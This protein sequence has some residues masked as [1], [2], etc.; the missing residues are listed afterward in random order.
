MSDPKRNRPGR[1]G[2]SKVTGQA[3]QPESTSPA[4]V[5]EA[6]TLGCALMST[7][8]RAG[9]IDLLDLD[10]FD[11]EAHRTLFGVL[12]KMHAAGEHVDPITVNDRLH[13]CGLLDEVGGGAAV[14]ELADPLVS[15]SPAA[16][17]NYAEIVVREGRRRRGIRVLQRGID[18]LEAGDDPAVVAADM[19]V[20]V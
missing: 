12:V 5:A 9:I 16:W 19:A 18:R 15:P 2:G 8:A 3:D 13:T 1:G 10:D 7:D 6:A 20:V 4:H 14:W 11:R 17:R